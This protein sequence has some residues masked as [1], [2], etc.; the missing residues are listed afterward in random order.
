MATITAKAIATSNST[1]AGWV[2]GGSITFD[3]FTS[4]D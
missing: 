3:G 2:N 1:Y 4:G